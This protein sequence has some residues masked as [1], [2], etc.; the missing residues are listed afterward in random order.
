M[1]NKLAL[2]AALGFGRS[3]LGYMPGAPNGPSGKLYP[4]DQAKR[5]AN[6]ATATERRLHNERI[7]AE[8]RNRK[9]NRKVK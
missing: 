8:K 3:I 4:E 2:A 1:K 5:Q 6:A 7:D 9:A